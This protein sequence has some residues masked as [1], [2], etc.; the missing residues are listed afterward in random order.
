[1]NKDRK[2]RIE[3]LLAEIE[4]SHTILLDVIAEERTAF[5]NTPESLQ[6]EEK[7]DLVDNLEQ[8]GCS[9]SD[10]IDELRSAL[11]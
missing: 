9:I 2:K 4:T 3:T 10:G 8:A 11:E 1:M 5:E 7:S 6:T